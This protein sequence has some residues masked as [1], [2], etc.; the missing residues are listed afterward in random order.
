[1]LDL[2]DERVGRADVDN[3]EVVDCVER[4]VLLV[5]RSESSLVLVEEE[6]LPVGGVCF[7]EVVSCSGLVGDGSRVGAQDG[8]TQRLGLLVVLDRRGF[9]TNE[10]SDVRLQEENAR[11]QPGASE[12]KEGGK[13]RTHIKQLQ[14]LRP[15]SV[16]V[17][18]LH[19]VDSDEERVVH[20]VHLLEKLGVSPQ[21]LAQQRRLLGSEVE[22]PVA[23]NP[24]DVLEDGP[25]LIFGLLL[26]VL[27]TSRRSLEVVR[28]VDV[29][30]GREEVVLSE[31]ERGS[32]RKSAREERTRRLTMMTKW[33][34]LPL[35]SLTR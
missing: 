3:A 26:G 7:S 4:F 6:V 32:Q 13:Q 19:L 16:P 30:V 8:L 29:A 17:P 35:G 20:N 21:L 11:S 5:R 24:V 18:P 22:R 10:S 14:V 15:Q 2:L 34:F 27:A 28:F 12:S 9:P 33:I 1:M 23:S 31:E 25:L